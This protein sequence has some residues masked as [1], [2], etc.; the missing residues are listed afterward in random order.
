MKTDIENNIFT[1]IIRII[2]D[3]IYDFY[4]RYY[5]CIVTTADIKL[6]KKLYKN[7][8]NPEMYHIE[9]IKKVYLHFQILIIIKITL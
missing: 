6:V 8:E 5:D 9:F 3:V 4:N 2:N 1:E 7:E